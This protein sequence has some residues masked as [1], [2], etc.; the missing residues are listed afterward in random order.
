MPDPHEFIDIGAEVAGIRETLARR[1]WLVVS[2]LALVLLA[3]FAT[4]MILGDY[5]VTLPRI[6][7]SLLSPLT[8]EAQRGIDFIVLGV[9]LPRALVAVM[10]GAAFGISGT[11]FQTVLRNPLAS[12]DIIGITAGASTAAVAAIV[13]LQWGGGMLAL[14]ALVGGL[15]TAGA[16]YAL[17]WHRGVSPYRVV[18]VGI[19]IAAVMTAIMSYMFTRARLIEVQQ[20]LTWLTGSLNG[21][22][23]KDATQLAIGAGIVGL[24]LIP[25]SRAA[26]T[27]ELGDDMARALGSRVERARFLLLGLA[28]CLCAIATAATGPIAFVALMAGPI[29]RLL[30]GPATGSLVPAALTGALVTLGADIVAQHF[31]AGVQLPVGVITGGIG[32]CFLILMLIAANRSGRTS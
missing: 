28:V 3:L 14:A 10:A 22:Q 30:L 19:G 25:L 20:A 1:R 21:M 4:A 9:R 16:I 15:G 23:M 7:A 29:A 24:L 12:P 31:I 2:G 17:A 6:V 13:L 5:P 27:L 18:L 26:G 8:G 11:L 32:A